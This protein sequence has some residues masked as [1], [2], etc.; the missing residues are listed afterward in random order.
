MNLIACV[1]LLILGT[2]QGKE[3]QHVRPRTFGDGIDW[4]SRDPG[5]D[6]QSLTALEK[7]NAVEDRH[8]DKPLERDVRPN[9][10][11]NVPTDSA[12]PTS[13]PIDT[14][15]APIDTT[16]VAPVELPSAEPT[17]PT[18]E[19]S[20]PTVSE[21]PT[22]APS[23]VPSQ[24]PSLSDGTPTPTPTLS[25]VPTASPTDES[26]V[27][28]SQAPSTFT[29]DPTSSSQPSQEPTT[30]FTLETFLF[31]T[32]TDNG[33]LTATGTPQNNA[34]LRL[35]EN[36]PELDPNDPVDQIEISQKY[37]LITLYFSTSGGFWANKTEWL[38]AS[39]SCD[40]FGVE[41]DETDGARILD[42]NLTENDLFGLLPSELRGLRDLGMFKLDRGRSRHFEARFVR[43]AN[44]F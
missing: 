5:R 22:G 11:N 43:R 37:A 41:C 32:L 28:P 1:A 44:P 20:E 36:N 3:R 31:Q 2:S 33:E 35:Q 14:T 8:S 26:S 34:F 27:A 30:P 40:W 7:K 6:L 10:F 12:T 18:T 13:A 24:Q 39:P 16:T 23:A 21:A 4:S 38:T 42:L 19:T 17:A 29:A 9:I 25:T 15:N